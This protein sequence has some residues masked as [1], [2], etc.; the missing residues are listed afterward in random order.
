[1]SEEETKYLEFA[2][3]IIRL[4]RVEMPIPARYDRLTETHIIGSSYSIL[5]ELKDV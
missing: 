1:M 5:G 3:A 4:Q 2:E